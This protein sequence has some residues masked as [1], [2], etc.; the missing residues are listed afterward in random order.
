MK[1]LT[2]AFVIVWLVIGYAFRLEPV[3]MYAVSMV[4]LIVFLHVLYLI[5][6]QKGEES[7]A[8]C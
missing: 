5:T 1:L 2:C 8:H 6:S 7:N 4:A 3:W